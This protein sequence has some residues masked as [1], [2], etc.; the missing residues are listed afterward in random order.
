MVLVV[1]KD[2]GMKQGKIA[3]QCAHAAVGIYAKL[4]RTQSDRLRAWE[5]Q[6]QPKVCVKADSLDEL[7][8]LDASARSL[9]LP[10]FVVQDAGRTQIDP[11]SSTVLAVGPG[12]KHK[13]DQVTGAQKLL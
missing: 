1:R 7:S 3:A 9:R 6:G 2:L 4:N 8:Q 5:L 11:G 12:P 13:V 10:T